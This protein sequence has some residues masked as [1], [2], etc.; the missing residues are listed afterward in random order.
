M[1][2]STH[3]INILEMSDGIFNRKQLYYAE[4]P[5][6]TSHGIFLCVS[7]DGEEKE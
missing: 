5:I 4:Y 1:Q 2:S 3:D 6:I 7:E